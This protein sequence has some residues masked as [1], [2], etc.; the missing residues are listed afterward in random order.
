MTP[1][2]E[3]PPGTASWWLYHLGAVALGV[4]AGLVLLDW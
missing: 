1:P 4:P 2:S 3:R